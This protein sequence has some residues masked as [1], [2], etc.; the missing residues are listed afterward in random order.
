MDQ[1]CIVATIPFP[2]VPAPNHRYSRRPVPSHVGSRTTPQETTS[3][4]HSAQASVTPRAAKLGLL[5]RIVLVTAAKS[6]IFTVAAGAADNS[7]AIK[8]KAP[9]GTLPATLPGDP[10]FGRYSAS[11]AGK[12]TT[13]A[14]RD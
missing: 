6:G 14:D 2:D 13:I 12:I 8:Y 11:K 5:L 3:V 10:V 1:E 4:V 9:A 7:Q